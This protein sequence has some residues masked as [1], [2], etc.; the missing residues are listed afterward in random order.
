[1]AGAIQLSN[2][3]RKGLTQ[4]H[5]HASRRFIKHNNGRPVHQRLR[6]QYAPFHTAG[7]RAHICIR[8]VRKTEVGEYLID[9]IV[10]AQ[11]AI[12]TGLG[13]QGLPHRK[14]RVKHQF[15]RY[16]AERAARKS[17]RVSRPQIRTL[18]PSARVK[19]ARMWIKVVL[20]APFGPSSP[21][22]SPSSMVRLMLF[23]ACNFG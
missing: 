1:M 13:A 17:E 3:F 14:K 21:K 2:K 6:N 12:V 16:N 5:I 19:P 10:I 7:E 11:Q 18:P 15:L 22:N 8:F 20:P 23:S 4:F 9:P